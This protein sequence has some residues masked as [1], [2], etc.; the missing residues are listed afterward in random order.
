MNRKHG[1]T[2]PLIA[3]GILALL[4]WLLP[5]SLHAECSGKLALQV[6]GSSGPTVD[7]RRASSGYLLWSDGRARVLLDA[8]GGSFAR[9]GRTAA[10]IEDLQLIA[11]SHF[12]ADHAVELP[13]YIKAGYFSDRQRALPVAG[14]SAG[15]KYP[16]AREFMQRLFDEKRG[17]FAYLSGTLNGTEGQFETPV[18][19]ISIADPGEQVVLLEPGIRI[20][21]RPVSHGP[22]PT[23]AYRI[24]TQ[25][26]VI[27]YGADQNGDDDTF[28]DF[29]RAADL[30]I[31]P[32]AIPEDA[33]GVATRLHA[34][35]SEI[36]TIAKR[37][38]ARRL[39]LSH[40]M[41]RSERNLG[42]QQAI[43]QNTYG[44]PAALAKDLLCLTLKQ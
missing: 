34:K 7:Q 24:E 33:T 42:E 14:P 9:F 29:A 15:G 3:N 11:I 25:D 2:Y 21:A 18:I 28:A 35:P 6:L 19:E 4:F 22:V 16:G 38:E 26:R 41:P 17:A 40:F 13:A 1:K 23:I 44:R 27:V 32:L 30:L 12:H 43:V 10:T 37:S 20:L 36:G 5:G 8:G 31:M 39:L